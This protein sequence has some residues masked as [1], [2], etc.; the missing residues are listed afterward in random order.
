MVRFVLNNLLYNAKR[1]ATHGGGLRIGATFEYA[2]GDTAQQTQGCRR[3]V[4][5]KFAV[6]GH[7]RHAGDK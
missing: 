1:A 7:N 3:G 4:G 2:G 6:G 5:I